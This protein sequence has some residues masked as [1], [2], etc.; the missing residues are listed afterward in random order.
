MKSTFLILVVFFLCSFLLP[1]QNQQKEIGLQTI[2]AQSIQGPLEFLASDWMT[3]RETGTA[4]E[5]MASDYIAAMYK[6]MGL[7]PGGSANMFN[8]SYFQNISFIQTK[9]GDRQEC[10]IVVERPGVNYQMDLTYKVDYSIAPGNQTIEVN[11]PVIFVGYGIENK[12]LKQNDFKG[13]DVKGKILIRLSGYPGWQD[14]DSKNFKRFSSSGPLVARQVELDK[15]AVALAKGAIAIIEV[16]SGSAGFVP[17][18]SNLPFRY[19]ESNYE[20]DVP[21]NT[22]VRYRTALQG[23]SGPGLTRINLSSKALNM[24]IDGSGIDFK[25]YEALA[26]DGNIKP[27]GNLADR[28]L[29]FVSSIDSKIVRGRNVIGVLEGTDTKSCIV[30]GAHYDHVGQTKGFIYN[31][32]DDN[33]SGTVGVMT[34]ARAMIA[35]G[36]KP[37]VSVIFCAWTAEEKGLLGSKYFAGHPL[38]EDIRCYMNYDMISRTAPDDSTGLKCDFNYSSGLPY[39]R[40]ITEKHIQDYS[41]RLNMDY[42][43]S[44]KPV[45]GSDFS[46]FSEKGIPIFLI[47]GKF[48][49]D[50]HQYTDHSDKAVL[51]YMTEIVKLGY[52]NIFELANR[53]W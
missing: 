34:I 17:A 33:A 3:G 8:P 35:T 46:S 29:K 22:E 38:I 1:A 26:A 27:S 19:N 18:P 24:L 11:A 16:R 49:P 42:K 32:S 36:V 43:T 21:F 4:G 50:Y 45:G 2:T 10:S 52:L 40:E 53:K 51:P 13:L 15:D 37:K 41:I 9:P 28:Y 20:G 23:V 31:G 12:K 44:P 5:F 7:K 30:V 48:T 39:L 6:A 47:H 14:P 25:T